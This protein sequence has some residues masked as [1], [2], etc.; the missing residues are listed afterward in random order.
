M[1]STT[2]VFYVSGVTARLTDQDVNLA[3]VS[4]SPPWLP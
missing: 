1:S 2:R 4:R 3:A